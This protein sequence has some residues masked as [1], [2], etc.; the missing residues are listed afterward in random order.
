LHGTIEQNLI[1][2]VRS[3]KRL[4]GQ[5]VHR[6]TVEHWKYILGLGERELSAE[7]SSELEGLRTF[8]AELRTEMVLRERYQPL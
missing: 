3:A 6:E 2:A 8:V 5:Q 1:S 4:R 7:T